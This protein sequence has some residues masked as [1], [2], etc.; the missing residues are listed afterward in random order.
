MLCPQLAGAKMSI[1]CRQRHRGGDSAGRRSRLSLEGSKVFEE[2]FASGGEEIRMAVVRSRFIEELSRPPK[3]NRFEPAPSPKKDATF[4]TAWKKRIREK[5]GKASASWIDLDSL[6]RI[7][8]RIDDPRH[9]DDVRVL[10]EVRR[11]R[12]HT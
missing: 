11:R 12:K 3:G 8:S 6:L 2:R 7:K 1:G 4:A 10:R 9:Q 5:Y